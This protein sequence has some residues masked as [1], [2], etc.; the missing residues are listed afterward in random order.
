MVIIFSHLQKY[1]KGEICHS[2]RKIMKFRSIGRRA[3]MRLNMETKCI[4]PRFAFAQ[5]KL[6]LRS[7]C[8]AT[9]GGSRIK[10]A[11]NKEDT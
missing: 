9:S 11:P 5:G 3:R 2:G 8:L 6:S 7:G 4:G 10:K 1:R